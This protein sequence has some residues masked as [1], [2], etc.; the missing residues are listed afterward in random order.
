[1]IHSVS[2]L[3]LV[4]TLSVLSAEEVTNLAPSGLKATEYTEPDHPPTD[5][6]HPR[7]TRMRRQHAVQVG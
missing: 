1:M 6:T 4:V 2:M 7:A 5:R 3:L